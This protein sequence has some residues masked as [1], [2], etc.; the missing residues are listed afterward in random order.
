MDNAILLLYWLIIIFQN[1]LLLIC[2]F[3]LISKANCVRSHPNL[4]RSL[5]EPNI[6][7]RIKERHKYNYF[8]HKISSP[9]VSKEWMIFFLSFCLLYLSSSI[10]TRSVHTDFR[11]QFTWVPVRRFVVQYSRSLRGEVASHLRFFGES[12]RYYSAPQKSM[13]QVSINQKDV[14]IQAMSMIYA[15]SEQNL[16]K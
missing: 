6:N 9:S 12:R 13:F 7:R 4:H 1:K 11:I 10:L 15:I 14:L 2:G 8:L 5:T 3:N 16:S